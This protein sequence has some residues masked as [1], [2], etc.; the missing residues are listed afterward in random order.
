MSSAVVPPFVTWKLLGIQ[1]ICALVQFNFEN[2]LLKCPLSVCFATWRT[3]HRSYFQ[4]FERYN[5]C[6]GW[7]LGWASV[8]H[9][10]IFFSLPNFFP[11]ILLW[12]LYVIPS[13]EFRGMNRVTLE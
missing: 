12:L 13:L 9:K 8:F 11:L 5:Y 6:A 4:C 1:T 7:L 2:C 3:Y 10:T